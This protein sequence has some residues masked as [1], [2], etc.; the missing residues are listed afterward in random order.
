MVPAVA[1]KEAVVAPAGTVTEATTGSRALLLE[2]G[3]LV[4]PEGAVEASVTVQVVAPPEVR[5]VGLQ[6]SEEKLT[7]VV[8]LIVAVLETPLRVAVTDALCVPEMVPAVAVKE[9][10]VAPAATVTEPGVVNAELLS[11]IVT[12]APPLG[13]AE[14]RVT[15]QVLAAPEVRVVGLQASEERLTGAVRLIAA[16]LETPLRVAVRVAL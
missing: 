13:A 3:T 9:A 4:P 1:V 10:V 7:A 12:A 5:A 6:A 15:V 8:R 11:E 16:L 14:V 2:S